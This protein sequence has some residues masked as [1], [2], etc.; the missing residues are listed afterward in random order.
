MKVAGRTSKKFTHDIYDQDDIFQEAYLLGMELYNKYDEDI[1]P[2]EN[3]I[4]KCIC[5]NF[6]NRIQKCK[7]RTKILDTLSLDIDIN[8]DNNE[9]MSYE[10]NGYSTVEQLKDITNDLPASMRKDYLKLLGGVDIS[11]KR[12]EAIRG[13]IKKAWATYD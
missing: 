13:E 11:N 9:S 1:G 3:F 10:E 4:S 2:A 7:I 12:K 6:L 8:L 5:N